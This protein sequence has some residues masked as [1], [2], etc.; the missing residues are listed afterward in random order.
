MM[1][2]PDALCILFTP[3]LCFKVALWYPNQDRVA[4]LLPSCSETLYQRHLH[5]AV[6]STDLEPRLSLYLSQLRYV[7]AVLAYTVC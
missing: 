1:P 3:P 4:I 7:L 6:N 5:L 2:L